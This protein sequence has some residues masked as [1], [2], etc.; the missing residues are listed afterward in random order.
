M[1]GV[2]AFVTGA[3]TAHFAFDVPFRT[4]CNVSLVEWS[5][6]ATGLVKCL[7]YGRHPVVAATAAF[8]V[9][10]SEG[11]GWPRPGSRQFVARDHHAERVHSTVALLA[12]GAK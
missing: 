2:V 4:F 12:L 1:G 5:D 11:V 6:L 3:V 9:R 8:Y 10:G 7:A